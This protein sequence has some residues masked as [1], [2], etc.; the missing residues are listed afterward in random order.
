MQ[1]RIRSRELSAADLELDT[2]TLATQE[3]PC[4]DEDSM[5]MT[6]VTLTHRN[7]QLVARTGRLQIWCNKW[8]FNTLL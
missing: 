6:T 3:T 2:Q 8:R 4:V 7:V 1:G 5:S